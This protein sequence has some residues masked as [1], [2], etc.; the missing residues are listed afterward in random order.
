[1]PSPRILRFPLLIGVLGAACVPQ[2]CVGTHPPEGDAG[3]REVGGTTHGGWVEVAGGSF[4]MGAVEGYGE[5]SPIHRVTVAPFQLGRTEVSVAEYLECVNAGR[6]TPA[7]WDDGRCE[8]VDPRRGAIGPGPLPAELRAPM[9]PISCIDLEQARAVCRFLG[10][11]LPTEAEWEFG[12]RGAVGHLYPWGDL[13]P[14]S[15]GARVANLPDDSGKA[16]FERWPDHLQGYDDGFALAAPVGSFPGGK[17]PV[18]ALDMVGNVWEWVEDCYHEGF[19]GA[20]PDGRAWTTG[21]HG[22]GRVVKG[23][24]YEP[25]EPP[26][27]ASVRRF[28]VEGAAWGHLGVRCARP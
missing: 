2:S 19:E 12:A 28:A 18:G 24:G 14:A 26:F 21:C 3:L 8:R 4:D 6:C 5:R 15:A 20:P 25:S 7:H 22:D 17:S 16:H 10:G 11:R 1:M 27:T 9:L 23:A 13:D